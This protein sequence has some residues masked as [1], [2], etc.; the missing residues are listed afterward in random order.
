M[1]RP[2]TTCHSHEY[3]LS[4]CAGAKH[5]ADSL[6][7]DPSSRGNPELNFLSSP[8]CN[9]LL[10]GEPHISFGLLSSRIQEETL[11]SLLSFFPFFPF[12]PFFL[13]I[14]KLIFRVYPVTHRLA[15][16]AWGARSSEKGEGNRKG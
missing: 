10:C 16:C 3:Q 11:S 1:T 6:L 13:E 7:S 12:L 15:A 14:A 4:T 8:R 2:P 5:W 9:F